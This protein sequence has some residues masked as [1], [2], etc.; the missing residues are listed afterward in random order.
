M[1]TPSCDRMKPS[2]DVSRFAGLVDDPVFSDLDE[3]TR[4]TADTC[5][6]K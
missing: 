3:C 6:Q 2:R 4:E 5:I 1:V